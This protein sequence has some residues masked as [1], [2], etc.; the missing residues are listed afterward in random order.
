MER[1]SNRSSKE[2]TLERLS[3]MFKLRSTSNGSRH[4]STSSNG[5]IVNELTEFSINP[6]FQPD[7]VPTPESNDMKQ[8]NAEMS[9]QQPASKAIVE[10]KNFDVS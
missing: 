1:L 10:P 7:V 8:A 3:A 4:S 2:T 9:T 6:T 5:I